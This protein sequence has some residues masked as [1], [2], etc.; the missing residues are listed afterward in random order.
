MTQPT[1]SSIFV[2]QRCVWRNGL[3][4][5]WY[6]GSTQA[7]TSISALCTIF[8]VNPKFGLHVLLNMFLF[9][10][11]ERFSLAGIIIFVRRETP[12]PHCLTADK[13]NLGPGSW[14]PNVAE[15]KRRFDPETTSGE[16]PQ[17]L[18]NLYFT[19]LVELRALVKAAPYLK[20]VRTVLVTLS[21]WLR[22][23]I[24][25]CWTQK[26]IQERQTACVCQS[27]GGTTW[28]I[29]FGPTFLISGTFLHRQRPG[30]RWSEKGR[31][32]F[33]GSSQVRKSI[34]MVLFCFV[35]SHCGCSIYA[36]QFCGKISL[37][38]NSK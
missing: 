13:L 23:G 36:H 9:S 8:L 27:W 15:F 1:N 21:P 17:W 10:S 33:A 28:R 30:R 16:G 6:R 34:T 37:K 31:E 22:G 19:Y 2:L 11:S 32:R 25:F 35:L 14:E 18:K 24:I 38:R 20:E 3:S 7:S 4:T 26:E 12:Q 29:Q 5:E